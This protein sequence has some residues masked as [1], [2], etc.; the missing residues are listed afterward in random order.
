MSSS[1]L[2]H[3]G[4]LAPLISWLLGDVKRELLGKCPWKK[5]RWNQ[6]TIINHRGGGNLMAF[7]FFTGFKLGSPCGKQAWREANNSGTTSDWGLTITSKRCWRKVV[8]GG[9]HL[10]LFK[11]QCVSSELLLSPAISGCVTV[12][13]WSHMRVKDLIRT[14]LVTRE[15]VP[16]C[17]RLTSSPWKTK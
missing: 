7:Q 13:L 3:K 2:R 1:E 14:F 4:A 12:T 8:L 10:V 11:H 9:S 16:G 15:N 5:E 6:L 17:F